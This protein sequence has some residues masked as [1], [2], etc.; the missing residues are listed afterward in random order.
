MKICTCQA[1]PISPVRKFLS[2]L[3]ICVRDAY[4]SCLREDVMLAYWLSSCS[5]ENGE[6][7]F[8]L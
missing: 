2:N 5:R 4:M 6:K 7:M 8:T 3:F 1:D